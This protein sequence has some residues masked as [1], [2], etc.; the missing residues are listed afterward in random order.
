MSLNDRQVD[1]YSRQIIV[2][3]MGGRAQERLLAARAIVVGVAG[4]IEAPIAYL[5]GAG[6]GEIAIAPCMDAAA[7]G[8]IIEHAAGLNPDVRVALA[9]NGEA[10]AGPAG[11]VLAILGGEAARARAARLLAARPRTP[12]VIARVD[13]PPAI[14]VLA[15]PPPCARCADWAALAPMRGEVARTRRFVAMVATVEALK[16]LAGPAGLGG[17]G[18]QPARLVEF[19]GG[20][21][22]ASTR[23]LARRVGATRCGCG[24]AA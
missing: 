21:Y 11:A 9:E 7:Y 15:A 19:T 3:G 1:R 17:T 22:A 4:D 2:A 8:S 10:D 14:A 20:G 13:V 6:V 18:E 24:D 5:A 16:L 12:A 23:V